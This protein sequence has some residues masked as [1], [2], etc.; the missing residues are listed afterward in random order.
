MYRPMDPNDRNA[1]LNIGGWVK[2]DSWFNQLI[3]GVIVT[4][5]KSDSIRYGNSLSLIADW[6]S[7]YKVCIGILFMKLLF[8]KNP[9]NRW[10][11]CIT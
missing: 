11:L 1:E 8:E 9:A 10:N 4:D 3:V 5:L 7:R 6:S 2:I